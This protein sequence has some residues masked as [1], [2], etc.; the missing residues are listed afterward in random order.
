MSLGTLSYRNPFIVSIYLFIY[1]GGRLADSPHFLSGL[2]LTNYR[3]VAKIVNF[4]LGVRWFRIF[5][6]GLRLNVL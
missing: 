6:S 4:S 5:R 2:W 1:F 3:A